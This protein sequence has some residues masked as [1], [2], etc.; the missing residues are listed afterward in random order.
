MVAGILSGRLPAVATQTHSFVQHIRDTSVKPVVAVRW[1]L[2]LNTSSWLTLAIADV[3]CVNTACPM[4]HNDS[5]RCC[6]AATSHLA[7]IS[8]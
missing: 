8:Q 5:Q 6:C 1:V 4:L 3:V 2:M 7:T